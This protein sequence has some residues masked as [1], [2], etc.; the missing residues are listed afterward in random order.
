MDP[1]GHV[2]PG[3]NR[4]RHFPRVLRPGLGTSNLVSRRRAHHTTG[5]GAAFRNNRR[6]LMAG[7]VHDWDVTLPT[8]PF[9]NGVRAGLRE[10]GPSKTNITHQKDRQNQI[11]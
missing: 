1:G 3:R 9:G 7:Q 6:F 2:I 11:I 5:V 8:V 10:A 4:L